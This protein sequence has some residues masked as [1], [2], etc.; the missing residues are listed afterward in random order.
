[1][2]DKHAM[3]EK[4][5]RFFLDGKG[6]DMTEEQIRAALDISEAELDNMVMGIPAF[7]R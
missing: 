2:P 3:L 1:M 4:M 6:Y 5:E 7:G